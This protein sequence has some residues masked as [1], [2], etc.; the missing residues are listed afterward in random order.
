MGKKIQFGGTKQILL[1]I[2]NTGR[3]QA[4]TFNDDLTD[5]DI[6]NAIKNN[7]L[8]DGSI[9]VNI[10]FGENYVNYN[11]NTSKLKNGCTLHITTVGIINFSKFT[12]L[13][14]YHDFKRHNNTNGIFNI[15]W[16]KP[17]GSFDSTITNHYMG[18]TK[19]KVNW[20]LSNDTTAK[21]KFLDTL[22]SDISI[23]AKYPIVIN[24]LL[25]KQYFI[26]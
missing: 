12:M 1:K 25:M 22:S 11:K 7:F 10:I 16:K 21:Q 20:K 6:I 17:V 24:F 15:S 2:N 26:Q 4:L 3:T 13:G 9:V 5:K 18:S 14:Y 8:K 23:K 19:F